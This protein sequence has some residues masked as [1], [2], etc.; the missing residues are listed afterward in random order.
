MAEG[1]SL[2]VVNYPH[3]GLL[4]HQLQPLSPFLSETLLRT[5][6]DREIKISY[7]PETVLHLHTHTHSL[8]IIKII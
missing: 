3:R 2:L 7:T 8:S 1:S 4:S 5:N 6:V